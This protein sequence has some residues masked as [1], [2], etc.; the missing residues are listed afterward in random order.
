MV[1]TVFNFKGFGVF[2]MILLLSQQSFAAFFPMNCDDMQEN[3]VVSQVENSHMPSQMHEHNATSQDSM[4]SHEKC[5]V[6]DS[7]D[8]LCDTLGLCLGSTHTIASQQ[9]NDQH[10]LFVDHGKRFIYPDESLYSGIALHPYRP[11]ILS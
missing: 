3:S 4:S 5:D 1:I 7:G 6:C 11:P 8:C 2:V 10:A 9:L